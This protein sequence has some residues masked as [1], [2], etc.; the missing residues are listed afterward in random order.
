MLHVNSA[1]TKYA[2]IYISGDTSLEDPHKK[3]L[4]IEQVFHELMFADVD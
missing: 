1:D 4:L 2:A 3:I